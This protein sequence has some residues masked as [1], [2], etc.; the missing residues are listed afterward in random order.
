MP[1]TARP[2]E[3][4][5]I[6]GIGEVL[7][8]LL[9][10]GKQLG[11]APA[12]FAYHAAAI[13]ARGVVA[14]CVGNDALGREVL[15]RLEKLG[16]ETGCVSTDPQHPTGTVEVRLDDRGVADYVI[17]ERAAWDYIPVTPP[18]LDLAPR[19][20]A[21]C[22]GT[23]GQRSPGSRH[24]IRAFLAATRPDLCLRAF[25]INLRQRHYSAELLRELLPLSHVLKLNEEELVIVARL[26]G[27]AGSGVGVVEQLLRDYPHLGLVALTRGERGSALFTRDGEVSDHPGVPARLVDTVGAGD[28]FTAALVTG[29]LHRS[30]PSLDEINDF[31]N[32]VA[33]YVCSQ[34]GATPPMPAELR[35]GA[36]RD[37]PG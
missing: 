28:A 31:A 27:I 19:A 26:L 18:L 21:A 24:A 11:G 25:D 14:S 22:F 5:I 13:G 20:D 1:E 30:S 9:P 35:W 12:N 34:P 15:Q 7:W 10:A 8:D 32:R 37:T 17:H 23:L 33:A 2:A 29:L 36:G 4:P 16:L 3:L 6:V